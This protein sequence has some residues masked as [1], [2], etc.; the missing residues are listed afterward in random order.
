MF[1]YIFILRID[2]IYKL[3][4]CFYLNIVYGVVMVFIDYN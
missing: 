1:V 2:K 4:E 3:S